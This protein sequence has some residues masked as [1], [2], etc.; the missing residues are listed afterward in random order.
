M[1]YNVYT[2]KLSKLTIDCAT[3]QFIPYSERIEWRSTGAVFPLTLLAEP[4]GRA[5]LGI[6]LTM[7][8]PFCPQCLR[9]F[10]RTCH[11]R[12]C[13]SFVL[14]L[15]AA[16]NHPVTIAEKLCNL[17]YFARSIQ[18]I[19]WVAT[20]TCCELDFDYPL[21][22]SHLLQKSE[23]FRIPFTRARVKLTK[24]WYSHGPQDLKSGWQP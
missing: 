11:P 2:E 24:R 21:L 22:K 23:N 15:P 3:V 18:W 13:T 19:H 7:M 20:E 10:R 12:C 9:S 16:P 17:S 4:S 1:G 6:H 8:T 14:L 5:F